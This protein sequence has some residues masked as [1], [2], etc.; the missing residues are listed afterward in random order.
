MWKDINGWENLYEVNEVGN[1]RNKITN[2]L[3]VGDKNSSG[4]QRVCL[5]NKKHI[6]NKQR[7]F[8]HRLVAEHFL[9]NPNNLPEVNHIDS[10]INNN[11]VDNLEWTTRLL[12]ERYSI[13]FGN[14]QYKNKPFIV[15]FKNGSNKIYKTT[16]SLA[17]EL[18]TSKRTILNWLHKKYL[19]YLK[20]GI[21]DIKYY[22]I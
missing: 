4:Y 9:E 7:F 14:K 19:T 12:N 21:E 10:N 17:N 15:Y 16:Q 13:E 22:Y 1:V 3:I 18:N 8:R 5:Y 11:S 6:P 20:Y 2:K